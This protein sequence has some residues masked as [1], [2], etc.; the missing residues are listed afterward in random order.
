MP[1]ITA[2]YLLVGITGVLGLFV[3][4]QLLLS[5]F[6]FAALR[7]SA[8]SRAQL[9]REMF[10]LVKKI[11][12]LTAHRREQMLKHYDK[13]LETLSSRLP[14]TI[15]AQTSQVIFET[16]SK[17]LARLAELEPNLSGDEAGRRKMDELIRTMEK[18]EQTIVVL[19]ADTVR[20]VMVESRRNLI[21]QEDL[22]DERMAA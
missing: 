14:P 2:N 21:E 13:I 6:M 10:G 16:E 3:G 1:E 8:K 11:E 15:A 9:D 19:A 18:L 17:I 22:S 5:I 20:N 7:N 4:L 12:G